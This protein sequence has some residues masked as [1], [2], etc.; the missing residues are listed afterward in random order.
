MRGRLGGPTL[1]I[2]GDVSFPRR[3]SKKGK[4]AG[5]TAAEEGC[6]EAMQILRAFFDAD[7]VG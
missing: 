5:R 1:L 4:S 3:N 6:R 7:A 2:P